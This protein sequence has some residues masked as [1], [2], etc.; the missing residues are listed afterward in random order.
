M[1]RLAATYILPLRKETDAELGELTEYLQK[2]SAI[3]DVIV[4]DN[5]APDIFARHHN[6]WNL[7]A[8]HIAP[9][10][11]CLTANPKVG[12]VTTGVRKATEAIVVADDDVRYAPDVLRE[13]LGRL[14]HADVVRPANYFFPLVWHAA[15]DTA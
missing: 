5:S 12:N 8:T 11:D 2:L 15:L 7:F 10:A 1:Q 13:I 6:T 4:V 9:D 3:V 14:T